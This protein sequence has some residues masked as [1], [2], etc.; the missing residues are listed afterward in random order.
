MIRRYVLAGTLAA[1]A[2]ASQSAEA[3]RTVGRRMQIIDDTPAPSV[4][5][6]AGFMVFGDILGGPFGANLTNSGGP[7]YG[8]Q[9]NLP[10]GSTLSVIGNVGYSQPDLQF[11]VPILGGMT[12]GKSDVWMYD[13][14]L[15]FSAPTMRGSRSIVPFLQV[16]AGGMKYDVQVSGLNRSASNV[17]FNA[18]VGADIPLAQNLGLRLFAKDYIGKFDVNEAAGVDYEAQTSHNFA[19]S[20]GL[21][22]QF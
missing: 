5:P 6:Y 9:A 21:K 14:G 10:L 8:I 4:S 12:F 1:I 15:Q 20:A 17:A 18:G 2:L 7:V 3:Q 11:G 16:G 13:A 19:L 22:L